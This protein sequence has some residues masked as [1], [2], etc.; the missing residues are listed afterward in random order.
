[1]TRIIA[2]CNQ[3][4]G[5][6]KTTT[7]VNLSA[8][9]SMAERRTLLIDADP[10]GNATQGVG[11]TVG[12]E[13]TLYEALLE[14]TPW[15]PEAASGYI[16]KTQLPFLDIVPATHHLAGAE[17][18]LVNCVSRE[19]RLRE[20]L[21]M[22]AQ[23]YDYILID[24]PP[25]LGLLTLNVLVGAKSVLIPIQCE[26]YALQGLAELL[27]TIRLTQQSFNAELQIEGALLTMHQSSTVLSKQV[28]EE[29]RNSF[30]EK[31]FHSVIPRTIKLAEAPS[32]G[33]PILLYD[34]ATP[35]AVAYMKLA[36]EIMGIKQ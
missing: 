18:E 5:V 7:A 12:D 11:V 25:S 6:G 3:K 19:T 29:V 24:A 2:I 30:Q 10:Q 1:M 31:V 4:G 27:N 28:V 8:A 9:L 35:G 36:Q 34:I 33:K 23:R 21:K 17:I 20:F 32:Y 15:T 26:Y 16:M 14:E 22:I 13:P